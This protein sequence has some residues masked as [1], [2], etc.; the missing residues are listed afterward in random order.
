[1]RSPERDMQHIRLVGGF[2][3]GIGL[4]QL[5]LTFFIALDGLFSDVPMGAAFDRGALGIFLSLLMAS[6]MSSC[7][8]QLQSLKSFSHAQIQNLRLVWTALVLLMILTGAAGL[9]LAPP[10]TTLA[11]LILLALFSIRGA[12]IRLSGD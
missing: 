10:L 5:L 8:V 11:V 3:L 4:M 9:W 6:I 1:M 2:L 12:L 7:A